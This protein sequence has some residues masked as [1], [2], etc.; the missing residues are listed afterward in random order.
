MPL[1]AVHISDGVLLWPVWVTGF[2]ASGV[3]LFLG[4]RRVRDEEIP[5]IALLTAAFFVASTIHVKVPPTSVHLLLN[6]LAG[7][8]LGSRAV[9]AISGGLFLQAV[10]IGHGGFYSLGVN[11]CVLSLP[12][13]LAF[14]GHRFLSRQLQEHRG[15]VCSLLVFASCVFLVISTVYSAAMVGFL[16]PGT[17]TWQENLEAATQFAM[18]PWILMMAV[19]VALIAAWFERRVHATGHFALGFFLGSLTV[20]VTS[21]LNCIVLLAGGERIWPVAPWALV[22]L[23]LPVAVLE[24]LVMGVAINFLTHVKPDWVMANEPTREPASLEA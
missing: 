6:G 7:V 24:G 23:H 15:M 4:S 22:V 2:V 1:W 9:I 16:M 8:L 14:A 3:L 18:Q 10:L 17:L 19:L 11:V 20:L 13:L 12:A 5:R 21:G